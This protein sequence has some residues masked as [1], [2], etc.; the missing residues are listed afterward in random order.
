MI[1]YSNEA[2]LKPLVP[3]RGTFGDSENAS[4]KCFIQPG[5]STFLSLSTAGLPLHFLMTS[6]LPW[7]QPRCGCLLC[8][9]SSFP[10][11]V[12]HLLSLQRCPS[13]PLA[14][15]AWAFSSSISLRGDGGAPPPLREQGSGCLCRCRLGCPGH[16]CRFGAQEDWKALL[17]K[18]ARPQQTTFSVRQNP[19]LR[20][21]LQLALN[22]SMVKVGRLQSPQEHGSHL[23]FEHYIPTFTGFHS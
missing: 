7:G 20:T 15:G 11:S 22:S 3:W 2:C 14:S 10:G 6:R 18:I 4:W 19:D 9:G 12:P 21:D 1:S 17:T 23:L 13:W 16:W 8:L 5:C